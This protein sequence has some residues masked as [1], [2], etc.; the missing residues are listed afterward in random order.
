MKLHVCEHFYALVFIWY[1]GI[2]TEVLKCISVNNEIQI[3]TIKS[4]FHFSF[5]SFQYFAC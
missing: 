1:G 2:L 5:E 3:L 4:L